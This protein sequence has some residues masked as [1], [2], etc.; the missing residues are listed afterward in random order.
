MT[1]TC[2]QCKTKND[3][4]ATYC[5]TFGTKL[6]KPSKKPQ[7]STDEKNSFDKR[8]DDFA[9]EMENI[10]KKAGLH[11]ERGI[12]NIGKDLD[13]AG[14]HFEHRGDAFERWYDRTFGVF[15]PLL[16]SILG[17]ILLWLI[18]KGMQSMSSSFAVFEP[19]S[20]FF[21]TYYWWF[22]AFMLFFS[23]TSYFT[24]KYHKLI[25]WISPVFGA[26][27]TVI[28]LWVAIRIFIIIS[29]TWNLSF[30]ADLASLFE[31]LLFVIAALVLVVGYLA[32]LFSRMTETISREEKPTL[33]QK[34]SEQSKESLQQPP[35]ATFKRLYRSGNN[36][37]L[38][39]VCGGLAEY[40]TIDPVIIRVLWIVGLFISFGGLVLAY[41]IFW[42]IVPRNPYH[43]WQ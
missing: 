31:I 33:L 17:I 19:L 15:G 9:D 39:G 26:V 38:G 13:A 5:K 28:V 36:R 21:L 8:V 4:D 30:F 34:R 32:L 27:G 42:I 7:T 6:V 1:V 20:T 23:Y 37:I 11:I 10:G 35:S 22:F 18:I 29:M 24:R 12:R 41:F 14:K 2:P 43:K 3:D 40:F 25:R 16:C